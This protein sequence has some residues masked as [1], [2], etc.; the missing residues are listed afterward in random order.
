M[1]KLFDK[2]QGSVWVMGE[3]LYFGTIVGL[4]LQS[5]LKLKI[6]QLMNIGTNG[7]ENGDW[8]WEELS[9]FLSG[10][11]LKMISSH[12][13]NPDC[14]D[15]DSMYWGGSTIGKFSV[16]LAISLIRNEAD[17]QHDRK[18]DLV[19]KAPVCERIRMFIWLALHDRLLSNVQRVARRLSD[20]PRCTRCGADEESLDH[21]LRRCPFSFIIWNK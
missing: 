3:E 20:D 11:T 1:Q 21:I 12:S 9:T 14:E 8:K 15:E 16:K 5:L 19:W 7:P 4:L 2:E 17:V 13:V 10:E 6:E 18:R